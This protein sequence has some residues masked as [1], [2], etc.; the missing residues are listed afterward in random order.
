MDGEPAPPPLTFVLVAHEGKV[1]AI[2]AVR[3][4]AHLGIVFVRRRHRRLPVQV[5]DVRC[6]LHLEE[7]QRA[8]ETV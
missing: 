7:R 6:T 2:I 8:M 4:H 3:E 5:E 1:Y